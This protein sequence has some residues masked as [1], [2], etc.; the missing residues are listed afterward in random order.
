L[1][2]G[3]AV[4]IEGLERRSEL[5]GSEARVVRAVPDAR[6]SYEIRLLGDDVDARAERPQGRLLRIRRGRLL[7]APGSPRP[8]SFGLLH[9]IQSRAALNGTAVEILPTR[10]DDEDSKAP[11][12]DGRRRRRMVRLGTG[13]VISVRESC[14]VPCTHPSFATDP[15]RDRCCVCLVDDLAMTCASP[16]GHVCACVRCAATLRKHAPCPICRRPVFSFV[17]IYAASATADS[18]PS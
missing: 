13:E 10:I 12:H 17:R 7:R 2:P 15:K 4:L 16:C 5:N 9:S 8:G 18:P 3:D 14:V 1:A 6:G 11:P